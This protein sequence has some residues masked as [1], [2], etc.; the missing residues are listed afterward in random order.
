ME[1][2]LDNVRFEKSIEESNLINPDEVDFYLMFR[3]FFNEFLI[4]MVSMIHALDDADLLEDVPKYVHED[5]RKQV[6]A[7]YFKPDNRLI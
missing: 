3:F 6:Y 7:E 5:L 2:A 4:I 1:Q